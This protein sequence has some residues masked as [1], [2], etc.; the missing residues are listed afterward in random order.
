VPIAADTLAEVLAYYDTLLSFGQRY[1]REPGIQVAALVDG[2]VV[3]EAAFGHANVENDLKLTERHLFRVA[4]HSKAVASVC[5]LQLVERGVLRLDDQAAT[6]VKELEGTAA[7]RLTIR[8]LLSH[9]SGLTRNGVEAD[10]WQLTTP[11]PSK[12]ELRAWLQDASANVV[13]DNVR[14]KYSNVGYGL[15]GLILDAVGHPF[16]EHVRTEIAGKLGLGDLTAERDP[17]RLDEYATGYSSL[18]YG[19]RI[20]VGNVDTNALAAATGV[21]STARDLA[22]FFSAALL[23]GDE[24]LLTDASKRVLG[25]PLWTTGRSQ[26]E[27]YALGLHVVRI[28]DN[29]VLGHGGLYPGHTSRTLVDPKRRLV[30]SVLVNAVDGTPQRYVQLPFKLLDLASSRERSSADLARFAGRFGSIFGLGDIA[31]LGGQLYWLSP[32]QDDP[33]AEAASLEVEGDTL[34]VTG[35]SGYGAFGESFRYTFDDGKVVSVRSADGM[36][37]RPFAR[38]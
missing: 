1:F 18:A 33:T 34:R 7:G 10:Y 8:D 13:E 14:F 24:R 17:D 25:H 32:D 30:V 36:L 35:G 12:D 29:E 6:H 22:T 23:P 31:L 28:G 16:D 19:D 26:T 9:G 3:Y 5:V 37:V 21:S 38:D 2:E 15:V 20:P 11:F 4:S 27:Q